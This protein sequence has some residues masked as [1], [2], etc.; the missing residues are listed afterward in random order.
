MKTPLSGKPAGAFVFRRRSSPRHSAAPR[1]GECDSLILPV[2]G[3]K[4]IRHGGTIRVVHRVVRRG[5][6]E[7]NANYVMEIGCE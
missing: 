2:V 3:G 6:I 4:P 7:A 1:M 5:N